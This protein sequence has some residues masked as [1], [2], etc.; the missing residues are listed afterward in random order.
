MRPLENLLWR[1]EAQ[2]KALSKAIDQINNNLA[3]YLRTYD[4]PPEELT[5]IAGK[6]ISL[7]QELK[8]ELKAQR[9]KLKM[10]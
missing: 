5:I 3:Y 7:K 10:N 4:T 9:N 6:L 8:Q 1:I 2:S